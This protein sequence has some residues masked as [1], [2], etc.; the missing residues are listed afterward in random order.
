MGKRILLF[1]FTVLFMVYLES[2]P[3]SAAVRTETEFFVELAKNLVLCREEFVLY[4]ENGYS[5]ST[6]ECKKL[7]KK[8]MKVDFKNSTNDGEFLSNNLKEISARKVKN[9]E[10]VQVEFQAKY[11]INYEQVKKLDAGCQRVIEQLHLEGLSKRKKI[12][13]ICEFV[14]YRVSYDDSLTN[15]SG[16]DALFQRSAVCQGYSSLVYKLLCKTG[17]KSHL[18]TGFIRNSGEYHSWNSVVLKGIKYHLDACWM[19]VDYGCNYK[20]LFMTTKEIKKER[21]IEGLVL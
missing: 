17:I 5:P 10:S 15:Y 20:Y 8:A 7:F 18:E 2:C 21:T 12:R 14:V 9:G 1:V 16:Y 13:R 3:V 11:V 19:D 4:C 6:I